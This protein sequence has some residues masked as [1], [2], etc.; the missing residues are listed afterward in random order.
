M[1]R[2]HR[3]L[4]H[5]HGALTSGGRAAN[6]RVCDQA[7]RSPVPVA[8]RNCSRRV[9][10][11]AAARATE[12]QNA[13]ALAPRGVSSTSSTVP[14]FTTFFVVNA[15]LV[16]IYKLFGL[17]FHDGIGQVGGFD[18]A[19]WFGRAPKSANAG[20]RS[21]GGASGAGGARAASS[22][23]LSFPGTSSRQ[24]SA[25]D[26]YD[27][28]DDYED[29]EDATESMPPGARKLAVL[30]RAH[31]QQQRRALAALPRRLPPR[32]LPQTVQADARAAVGRGR[33]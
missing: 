29:D 2:R 15:L 20:A 21:S 18:I 30:L 11:A 16:H 22:G 9:A 33:R 3:G 19:A 4:R 32:R 27:Y 17:V 28:Y 7:A 23:G 14:L 31:R 10:L 6:Q 8:A 1:H 26:E 25:D 12:A 24:P 13:A 5:A